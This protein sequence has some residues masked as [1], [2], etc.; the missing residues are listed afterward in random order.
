[1]AVGESVADIEQPETSP[2]VFLDTVLRPYRS[3][4]PRGFF[5]L[6]AVLG[7]ASLIVGTACVL[8]GAWPVFG[9][10]GLDVALVYVAFRVS[11]RGA[12]LSE[13]VR[14]TERSLTVE[15]VSRRGEHRHWEFE[16]YWLRV[17][18]EEKGETS[19]LKLASHGRAIVLG[20]FLAPLERQSF[21]ALLQGALARWRA[22][23][24]TP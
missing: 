22:F 17:V 1:M 24:A 8:A 20:S 3:L 10:F 14:L 18:L 11:Y 23:I 19:T 5:L 9:F 16:P 13:S 15:R 4:A 7:G 21:A 6:M 12:R 2:R